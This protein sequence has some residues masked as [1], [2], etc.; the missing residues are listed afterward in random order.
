[1]KERGPETNQ[2][3]RHGDLTVLT[4][5]H[6]WLWSGT[7]QGEKIGRRDFGHRPAFKCHCENTDSRA[8]RISGDEILLRLSRSIIARNS[9]QIVRLKRHAIASLLVWFFSGIDFS[10]LGI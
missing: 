5:A 4:W 9:H 7:D 3:I 10:R 2:D 8:A 6:S 1:M